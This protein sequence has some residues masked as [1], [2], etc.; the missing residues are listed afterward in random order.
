M[1]AAEGLAV[2][3]NRRVRASTGGGR[4]RQEPIGEVHECRALERV[5]PADVVDPAANGPNL[6]VVDDAASV[7]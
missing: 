1:I 6:V 2:T 4:L 5:Q 7:V 3:A